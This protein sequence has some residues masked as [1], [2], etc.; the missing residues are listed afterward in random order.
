MK[1]FLRRRRKQHAKPKIRWTIRRDMPEIFRIENASF[2]R[3]W[4]EE[5]FLA[6]M[7]QRNSI[8][9]VA[10]WRGRIVGYALYQLHKSTLFL[11]KIAVHPKFRK[12]HIGQAMMR[13]LIQ[14]RS[15]QKNPV[16][17]VFINHCDAPT[18]DPGLARKFF[19]A[20]DS[21]NGMRQHAIR[22]VS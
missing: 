6:F 7:R 20:C 10:E 16:M 9:V 3:A 21:W 11:W 12:R 22:I 17:N 2:V 15:P 1:R 13:K 4:T 5:D 18:D 19:V 14:K 8:G